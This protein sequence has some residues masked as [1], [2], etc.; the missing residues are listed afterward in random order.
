MCKSL[1]KVMCKT[2]CK[3]LCKSMCKIVFKNMCKSML[4][5]TCKNGPPTS[6]HMCNKKNK[7]RANKGGYEVAAV[8]FQEPCPR[9]VPAQNSVKNTDFLSTRSSTFCC[10]TFCVVRTLTY[11]ARQDRPE[12]S[13]CPSGLPVSEHGGAPFGTTGPN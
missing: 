3:H 9:S 12:V 2:R 4:K 10:T 6:K 8:R 13:A 7:R 5:T 1:C 11:S